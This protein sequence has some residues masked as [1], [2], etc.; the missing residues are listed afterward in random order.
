MQRELLGSQQQATPSSLSARLIRDAHMF[1]ETFMANVSEDIAR[2]YSL[3]VLKLA[4]GLVDFGNKQIPYKPRVVAYPPMDPQAAHSLSLSPFTQPPA[5]RPP[6][7]SS[8]GG[9][10]PSFGRPQATSVAGSG[11]DEGSLSF[12]RDYNFEGGL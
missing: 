2:S 7:R 4:T 9:Q 3:E 12:L 6:Q 10:T 8:W 11:G 1:A 5:Q